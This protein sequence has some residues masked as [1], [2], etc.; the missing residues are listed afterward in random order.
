MRKFV[1]V[2]GVCLPHVLDASPRR[3]LANYGDELSHGWLS[4]GHFELHAAIGAVTN[5]S[6]D[7]SATRGFAHEPPEAYALHAPMDLEAQPHDPIRELAVAAPP[8][9]QPRAPHR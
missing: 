8:A 1:G 7:S 3:S 2:G 6:S 9:R 4:A 5:P